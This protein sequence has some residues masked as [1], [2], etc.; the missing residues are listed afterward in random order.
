MTPRYHSP[1]RKPRSRPAQLIVGLLPTLVMLTGCASQQEHP[2]PSFPLSVNEAQDEIR[3]MREAP[4]ELRRPVVVL[5]GWGDLLG[6]P[7]AHLAKEL[8]KA[9]G[10]D[11]VIAIGF[12]GNVSFDGCRKRM[13]K[14]LEQAFPS[15]SDGW[16]AEVD[17]IGF[18]MGGIVARYAALPPADEAE[19]AEPLRRLRIARLYTISTPHRGAAIAKVIAPGKLARD[20][21][22]GSEFL[23]TLDEHLD[24]DPYPVLSYTRLNDGI[25]GEGNTAPH[26]QEPYWIPPAPLSISHA[27]AYRDPRLI[28]DLAR[29]LRDEPPYTTDPPTPLPE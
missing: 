24:A 17:V 15:E 21:K 26:G 11:R 7:P 10:D 8:R 12:G 28:A 16:T 23:E 19:D 9:T 29:R 27:Q 4:V 1:A 3:L 13:L 20:M 18:S 2:N 5:G 6:L 14:Q 22:P 25:V